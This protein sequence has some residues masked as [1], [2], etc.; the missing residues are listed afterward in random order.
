MELNGLGNIEVNVVSVFR[1]NSMDGMYGWCR[2]DLE[3]KMKKRS[4]LELNTAV[5]S[6]K[7]S[8]ANMGCK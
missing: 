2:I 4:R 1:D 6:L 8:V 7:K 5:M 3:Y